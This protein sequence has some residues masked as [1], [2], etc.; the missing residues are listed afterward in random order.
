MRFEIVNKRY[1]VIQKTL[2]SQR[3]KLK[4]LENTDLR[5]GVTIYTSDTTVDPIETSDSFTTVTSEGTTLWRY[6]AS[7]LIFDPAL[8][9]YISTEQC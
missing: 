1:S 2:V 9:V 4:L 6:V 5:Y 7:D 3:F 8:G